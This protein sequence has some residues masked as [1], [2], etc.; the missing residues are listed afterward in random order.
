MHT[1]PSMGSRAVAS[2]LP[3]CALVG[4]YGTSM[5]PGRED[6]LLLPDELVDEV[7]GEGDRAVDWV[8]S[9]P[10]LVTEL[11]S[12]WHVDLDL[13]STRSGANALVVLGARWGEPCALKV[14]KPG[15]DLGPEAE[16][17][18]VWDGHGAVRLHECSLDENALLLEG[19]D[20]DRP[21]SRCPSTR[22]RV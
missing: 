7:A 6:E 2:K 8:N 15:Y 10:E 12:R 17:L 5:N 22:R 1:S 3:S 16:A 9:L 18:R 4:E 13:R 19:L 11:A 21:S 14:S 20:A